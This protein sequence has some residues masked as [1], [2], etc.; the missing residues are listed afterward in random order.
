MLLIAENLTVERGMRA[1]IRQLSLRAE[2][3]EALVLTGRN[4]SGKTTLLRTIA[5][6]LKPVEGVLRLEGGD[7]ERSIGE[8]AHFVGHANAVKANLTVL[9]NARFFASYLGGA[10]GAEARAE[11]ALEHFAVRDLAEFPAAYLSAG[12]KRRLGLARLLVAKRPLWLLD[13][14]TVSLDTA[15]AKLLSEAV[16]A[17]LG[18]GGL[19]I[20][21]THLPL[22]FAR[23][24]EFDVSAASGR[25]AA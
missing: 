19:V 24:R 17:H 13:E 4:G 5:G 14:P 12:Q 16:N 1:I 11:A 2:A 15:S 9:E 21:A 22:G 8:Q 23:A 7:G 3:G 18:G 25:A 6:F 10:P 20:A